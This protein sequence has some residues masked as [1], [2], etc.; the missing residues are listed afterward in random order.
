MLA[1]TVIASALLIASCGQG[2]ASGTGDATVAGSVNQDVIAAFYPLVFVAQQVGSTHVT[3]RDLTPPG[4]DS[5]DLEL[6]PRDVAALQQADL[7][8][9]LS[10]FTPALDEVIQPLSRGQVFD[11]ALTARLIRTNDDHEDPDHE[12]PDGDHDDHLGGVDPHFWLDPT[13]LADVAD[14]VAE[15]FAQ[16]DPDNAESFAANTAALRARLEK[17]D[18]EYRRGLADC[19]HLDLVTAHRSFGYLADRYG[20]NQIGIVGLSPDQEPSAA[21]LAR[22]ADFVRDRDVQVIFYEATVDPGVAQTVADETGAT[23]DVLNPLESLRD[24]AVSG[25]YY[26]EVMQSNLAALRS[27]LECT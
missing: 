18:D 20:L 2:I 16:L 19:A 26:F 4:A 25:D 15:R 23:T 3:V 5:H 21:Q 1:A 10:G 8:I 6:T 24:A 22:V 14:A 11:A 12:D 7:V 27:G 9:H 13:R 17:L